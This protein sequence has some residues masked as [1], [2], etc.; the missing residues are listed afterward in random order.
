M[1]LGKK[2]AMC[3]KKR[4]KRKAPRILFIYYLF[5]KITIFIHMDFSN[6]NHSNHAH[7]VEFNK[8]IGYRTQK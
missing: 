6:Q 5:V 3:F 1:K 8:V 2:I 4:S 7:G